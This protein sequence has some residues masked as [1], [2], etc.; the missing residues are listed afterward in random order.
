[1]NLKE[2]HGDSSSRASVKRGPRSLRPNQFLRQ[3]LCTYEKI[4]SS[5]RLNDAS[6][7]LTQAQAMKQNDGH[8]LN[9]SL[10]DGW[11]N[12]DTEYKSNESNVRLVLLQLAD[13]APHASRLWI[14]QGCQA[15]QRCQECQG[16]QGWKKVPRVPRAG[17]SVNCRAAPNP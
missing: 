3:N 13:A 7:L 9:S 17:R 12:F 15:C 16:Y 4:T 1:M 2:R 8:L 11:K 6:P 10:T 14:W 5:K